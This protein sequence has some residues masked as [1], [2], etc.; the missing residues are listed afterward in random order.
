[1]AEFN[2]VLGLP[3]KQVASFNLSSSGVLIELFN[4]TFDPNSLTNPKVNSFGIFMDSDSHKSLETKVVNSILGIRVDHL[5][6]DS[7]GGS[8]FDKL[9]L[10]QLNSKISRAK[11]EFAKKNIDLQELQVYKYLKNC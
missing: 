1:M 2:L 5:T 7:I 4:K 3:L 9:D 8:S 10:T 6:I 11:K